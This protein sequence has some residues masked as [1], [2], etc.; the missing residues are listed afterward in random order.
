MFFIIKQIKTNFGENDLYEVV[1]TLEELDSMDYKC[2][3]YSDKSKSITFYNLP[4]PKN[5][6]CFDFILKAVN[7]Y[8]V[9]NR[10]K[11]LKKI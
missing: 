1:K 6:I 2:Y 3:I 11:K 7:D 8:K 5:S 9:K 4:I 10:I